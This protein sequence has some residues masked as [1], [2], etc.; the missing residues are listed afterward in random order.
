MNAN[1]LAIINLLLK[2]KELT[3]NELA[4]S[5]GLSNTHV[6][7]IIKQLISAGF[8]E[9]DEDR[10][11]D[12]KIRF[13]PSGPAFI[14][15][16][17]SHLGVNISQSSWCGTIKNIEFIP[18]GSPTDYLSDNRFLISVI[19]EYIAR[20]ITN[21]VIGIAISLHAIVRNGD[22]VVYNSGNH[23]WKENAL[24]TQLSRHYNVNVLL[25]NVANA[26]AHYYSHEQQTENLFCIFA[27]YSIGSGLV[28]SDQ[29]YS[30]R[31]NIAGELA[32][33]QSGSP[34]ECWCG[35]TGCLGTVA[36]LEGICRIA[37]KMATAGQSSSGLSA[38]INSATVNEKFESLHL[39]WDNEDYIMR[40]LL[41]AACIEFGKSVAILDSLL[42][43]QSI[44]I[45]GRLFNHPEMHRLIQEQ[46]R[47]TTR[48][49]FYEREVP[50][51]FRS[52][53]LQDL[54]A[55]TGRELISREIYAQLD[56]Y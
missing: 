56:S 5:T 19:D 31:N 12:R 16:E 37:S 25:N 34:Y 26:L 39:S 35:Q 23:T 51:N 36:S 32:H 48:I 53:N 14:I 44:T 41:E 47:R 15:L 33:L 3:R 21:K 28:F 9:E 29:L 40:P 24:G 20:H 49:R 1:T 45:C 22:T 11:R 27:D 2:N 50:L 43:T 7:E 46:A 54:L 4:R 55:G 13:S 10:V 42:A 8:L 17:I 52:Y 38:L 6:G 18:A 30:G